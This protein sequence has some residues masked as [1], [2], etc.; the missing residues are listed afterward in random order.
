VAADDEQLRVASRVEWNLCPIA[1]HDA[2]TDHFASMRPEGFVDSVR[3]LRG[4]VV[5]EILGR[6]G[7]V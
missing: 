6:P 7:E 5:G 4:G 1:G 3:K 2:L